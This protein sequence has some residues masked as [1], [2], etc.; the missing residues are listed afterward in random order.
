MA[1]LDSTTNGANSATPSVTVPVGAASG[2]I[3]LGAIGIDSQPDQVD[4]ADLPSGWVEL[5]ETDITFDGQTAWLGYKRL[6]AADAGS[7]TWGSVG[8]AADYVCQC[9]LLSGRHATNPPVVSAT[10]VVNTGG[11]GT[12]MTV[13]ANSVTALAG[14]DLVWVSVPD[15]NASGAGNGHTAPAGYTKAEDAEFLWANLC[16][17]YKENVGAGATGTVSG[18]FAYT[19]N[20]GYAAWLV[21]VPAAAGGSSVAKMLASLGVG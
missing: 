14:D 8:S 11:G 21:R 3:A 20:A 6:S 18:S 2:V 17:A 7:Y 13:T 15:V 4:P 9:M 19:S 16:M 12:S 1:Y 10:A 5:A